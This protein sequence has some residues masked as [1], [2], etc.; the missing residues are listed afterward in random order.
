MSKYLSMLLGLSQDGTHTHTRTTYTHTHT[1]TL[2]KYRGIPKYLSILL[3]LSQDGTHIHTYTAC[4]SIVGFPNTQVHSW[5]CPRMVHTYTH[6]LHVQVS[7]DSQ[8]PKYTPGTVPGWYTHTQMSK[9]P[10]IPKYLST[11]LGLSQDGTHIYT[12][13]ACPSILGFPNTLVHSW[14]CPM[15]VHTYTQTLHVQVSRDS[16]IPKGL[17]QDGTHT[18]THS[19]HKCTH[20]QT[21]SEYLEIPKYISTLRVL[22]QDGTHTHSKHTQTHTHRH[23]PRILGFPST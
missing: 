23:C 16:Q 8:T 12:Y 10:G 7:W 1:H 5:D 11:L 21:L 13:T 15:M 17:S 19:K 4:P 22:S 18:H 20:T 2:S 3:G 9:Y 6:T 14:N